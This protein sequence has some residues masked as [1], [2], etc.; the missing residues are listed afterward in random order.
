MSFQGFQTYFS[1][2][3][4]PTLFGRLA[5]AIPIDPETFLGKALRL[6]SYIL[7]N[8]RILCIFPEGGR[9]FD[10]NLMPFKRGIGI[11]ALQHNVPVVPVLIE[12]TFEALPRGTLWP[13]PGAIKLSFGKPLYPHELNPFQRPE[14][15]DEYQVFADEIRERV[16]M[17]RGNIPAT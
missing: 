7:R 16:R 17:L 14:G 1:G 12:G 2:W 13:R 5:H 10:G 3:W 15:V 6:S 4:L 8:N 11:L 9:S